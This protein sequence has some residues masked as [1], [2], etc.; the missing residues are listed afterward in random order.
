MYEGGLGDLP[1]DAAR[2]TALYQQACEGG[3]RDGCAKIKR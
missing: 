1:T 2:A 3:D